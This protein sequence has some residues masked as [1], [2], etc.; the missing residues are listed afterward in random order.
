MSTE[1]LKNHPLRPQALPGDAMGEETLFREL[2][3]KTVKHINGNNR[4]IL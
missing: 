4:M 2:S 3:V 1:K